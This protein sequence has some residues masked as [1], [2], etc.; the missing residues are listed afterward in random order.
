MTDQE[1]KNIFLATC[2]T[3]VETFIMD[4]AFAYM[5]D[6]EKKQLEDVYHNHLEKL[7]EGDRI[8]EEAGKVLVKIHA[9]V[10]KRYE[11]GEGK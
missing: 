6:E 10:Y 11:I 4:G 1:L 7:N 3:P 8:P 2:S 5:N 9:D